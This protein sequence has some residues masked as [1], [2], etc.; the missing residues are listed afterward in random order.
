MSERDSRLSTFLKIKN[1]Q[2]QVSFLMT[3]KIKLNMLT[4]L[5]AI[6]LIFLSRGFVNAEAQQKTGEWKPG[7]EMTLG[8]HDGYVEEISGAALFSKPVCIQTATLYA[9]KKGSGFYAMAVNFSPEKQESEETDFYAGF[10]TDLPGVQIDAGYA[11]YWWREDLAIDFQGVYGLFVL[12][13]F[14]WEIYPFVNAEYRFA[15]KKVT[16]LYPDISHRRLK[17]QCEFSDEDLGGFLYQAG[18]KK[19]FTI[20]KRFSIMT[21]VSL[22]GNTGLYGLSAENLGFIREKLDIV[23]S[24]FKPLTINI[25]GMTQQNL[26]K[27]EGIAADTEKMFVSATMVWSF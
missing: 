8:V 20:N 12:P 24:P 5:T 25:S 19:N 14:V 10:Y 16:D 17:R 7:L 21:E 23:I 4:F 22:G 1:Q 11:Y 6:A 15:E 18:F 3:E 13:K 2:L 26:G 27:E 9:E